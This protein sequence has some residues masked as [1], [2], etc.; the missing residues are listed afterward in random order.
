MLFENYKFT[1]QKSPDALTAHGKKLDRHWI[2]AEIYR[3]YLQH[4]G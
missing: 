3:E 2:P 1:Q 4:K